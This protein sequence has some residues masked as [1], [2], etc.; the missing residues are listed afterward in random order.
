MRIIPHYTRVKYQHVIEVGSARLMG[1]PWIS[2]V[3]LMFSVIVAM[4]LANLPFTKEAYHAF[5]ETSLSIT[6]KSH[7][8]EWIFPKDMTVEKFI[9]DI[10]M[11]VFF[12]TVGLEIKREIVCGELSSMKKAMLPVIAA[13]GGMLMPA[14]IYIIVN[15]GTSASSGWAMTQLVFPSPKR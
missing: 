4:L 2:G 15:G 10:L 6:V 12:F 5:L 14:L 9:N 3:L 7:N 11:V 1:K 13:M 8:F